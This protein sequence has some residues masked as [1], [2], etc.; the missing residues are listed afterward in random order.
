MDSK[1]PKGFR[2]FDN[3]MRK[4]VK[5]RPSQVV[6][7]INRRGCK[8]KLDAKASSAIGE[9]AKKLHAAFSKPRKKK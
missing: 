5:V 7:G 3:L 9:A 6:V 8:G 4:L 2:K 1:K